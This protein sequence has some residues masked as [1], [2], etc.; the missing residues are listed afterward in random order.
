MSNPVQEKAEI[1]AVQKVGEYFQFTVVAPDVA[2]HAKPGQFVAVAVG[3]ENSSML[4]RRAFALYGAKPGGEFAG[5][6]RGAEDAE[7]VRPHARDQIAHWNSS[8][9]HGKIVRVREDVH[10]RDQPAVAPADDAHALGVEEAVL[11]QHPLHAAVDV[12]DLEATV[13]N[14]LVVAA[15]ITC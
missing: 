2:H 10:Q 1:F 14:V 12:V 5:K 3:G 8:V 9:S 11:V 13:V 4:L 7:L 15:S 6:T